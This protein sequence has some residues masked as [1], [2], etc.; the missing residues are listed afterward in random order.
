MVLHTPNVL[1]V[2]YSCDVVLV[3]WFWWEIVLVRMYLVFNTVVRLCQFFGCNGKAN[4]VQIFLLNLRIFFSYFLLC[5]DLQ[6]YSH[7][8]FLKISRTLFDFL[9]NTYWV[10]F[11]WRNNSL[12]FRTG[13]FLFLRNTL[14]LHFLSPYSR[15][16]RQTESQIHSLRVG[17]RN[18]FSSCVVSV[19]GSGRK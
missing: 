10:S 2:P 15:T 6:L 19:F 12:I 14:L 16:E 17:W 13:V 11:F 7:N 4:L 18:F 3:F 9:N 1:R 8:C 5:M